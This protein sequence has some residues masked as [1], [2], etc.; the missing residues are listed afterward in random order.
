LAV[1]DA[2]KLVRLR[3]RPWVDL[4]PGI[5]FLLCTAAFIAIGIYL[6][7]KA[8]VWLLPF[9]TFFLGFGILFSSNRILTLCVASGRKS[10]ESCRQDYQPY[11]L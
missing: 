8:D 4:A 3:D 7:V 11:F 2:L 1:V 9:F 10:C 5:M 6:A